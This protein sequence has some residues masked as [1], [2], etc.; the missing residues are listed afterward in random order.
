MGQLILD[1]DDETEAHLKASAKNS[2]LSLS[3]WITSLVREKAATDWPSD[4]RSL[5]GAWPDFPDLEQ[6]RGAPSKDIPRES[7]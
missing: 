7:I 3:A 2:G 5:A 6:L 1:L 4:I